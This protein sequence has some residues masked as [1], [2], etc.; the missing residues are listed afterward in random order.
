MRIAISAWLT[1]DVNGIFN[2][3]GNPDIALT[4]N[5]FSMAP[6]LGRSDALNGPGRER[7]S[8]KGEVEEKKEQVGDDEAD[9]CSQLGKGAIDRT[10][11]GRRILGGEKCGSAPLPTEADSLGEPEDHEKQWGEH[12]L[13]RNGS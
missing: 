7:V 1:F 9:R 8:G 13:F 4:G 10:L 3:D 12:A 6:E 2:G 5:D 11:A